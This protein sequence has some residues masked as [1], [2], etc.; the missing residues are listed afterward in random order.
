MITLRTIAAGLLLGIFVGGVRPCFSEDNTPELKRRNSSSVTHDWNKANERLAALGKM[1]GKKESYTNEELYHISCMDPD[2]EVR[3]LAFF[4]LTRSPDKLGYT[5]YLAADSFKR[6]KELGVKVEKAVAM[7]K[8]Q[9]KWSALNE[10]VGFLR[11]LRWNDWNGDCQRCHGGYIPAGTP[12]GELGYGVTSEDR[13]VVE[14]EHHE[15]LQC[16]NEPELIG[17]ICTAINRLAGTQMGSRPRIDQEIVKWWERK[18]E[19]WADYDR[20]LRTEEL[21]KEKEL[22]WNNN[23]KADAKFIKSGQDILLQQLGKPDVVL[24]GDKFKRAKMLNPLAD[25]DDE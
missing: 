9:Y 8:L 20:K 3:S 13:G 25:K 15:V 19:L 16:R 14:W 2:P 4:M 12:P 10:L 21:R 1:A 7:N 23:A 11:T 5:A 18:S 6:E 17:H 24:N 22:A